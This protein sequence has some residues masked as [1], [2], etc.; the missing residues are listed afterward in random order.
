MV[1]L[2][3]EIDG[4]V[5][6]IR[7]RCSSLLGCLCEGESLLLRLSLQT[8]EKKHEKLLLSGLELL[9]KFGVLVSNSDCGDL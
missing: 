6:V 8:R 2:L 7:N 1:V 5:V 9:T 3:S 4:H